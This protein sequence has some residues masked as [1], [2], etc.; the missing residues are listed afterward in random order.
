MRFVDV[1]AYVLPFIRGFVPGVTV[2]TKVP[3]PRPA[4]FVRAWAN[5]GAAVNRVLERAQI[6]VDVW[7]P[8]TTEAA[9]LAGDIRHAFLNNS[10]QLVLVRAVEEVTRPYPVPDETSERYRATYALTIRAPR[11]P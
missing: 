9:Y 4:V 1:E 6:T 2:G 10:G 8:S 3:N 7:A 11:R 5:G